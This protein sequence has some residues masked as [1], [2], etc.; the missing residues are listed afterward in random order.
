MDEDLSC[1]CVCIIGVFLIFAGFSLL[2]NVHLD[3]DDYDADDIYLSDFDNHVNHYSDDTYMYDVFYTLRNVS[4]SFEDSEVITYF[5]SNDEVVLSDEVTYLSNNTTTPLSYD[6][7][8]YNSAIISAFLHS[9]NFT[10][11]THVKIVMI[12]DGK[13][14]FNTT[15][16]FDMSNTEEVD[17]EA[18]FSNY[19]DLDDNSTLGLTNNDDSFTGDGSSDSSTDYGGSYVASSNSNKFHEPSCSYAHRIKDENRVTFS[20]RDDA[21]SQGYEPCGVCYP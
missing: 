4:T 9:D 7:I 1:C 16:P 12:K 3:F 13:I 15:K 17:L 6:D 10:N 19:N 21:I 18:N 2:S 8:S 14:I 5:Y 20:S 11:I